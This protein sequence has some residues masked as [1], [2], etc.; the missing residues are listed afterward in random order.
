MPAVSPTQLANWN[1][2]EYYASQ[3]ECRLAIAE[4]PREEYGRIVDAGLVLQIDDPQLAS[5]YVPRPFPAS[6]LDCRQS[7]ASGW[8]LLSNRVGLCI[9][10]PKSHC[11]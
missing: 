11:R 10:S 6:N 9:S 3:E 1:K 8:I 5:R 2:I 7:S 4:A